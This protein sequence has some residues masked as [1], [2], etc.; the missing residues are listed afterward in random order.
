MATTCRL[1]Y[2]LGLRQDISPP[3]LLLFAKP[4]SFGQISGAP[5]AVLVLTS[6]REPPHHTSHFRALDQCHGAALHHDRDE[7]AL[8]DVTPV[9]LGSPVQ[10]TDRT[11]AAMSP[12]SLRPKRER[13]AIHHISLQLAGFSVA[14]ERDGVGRMQMIPS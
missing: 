4:P 8:P 11:L 1:S 10:D 13:M 12:T 5:S 3:P 9:Y 2:E 6:G 7:C 14:C